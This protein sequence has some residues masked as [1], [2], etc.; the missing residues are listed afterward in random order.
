MTPPDR[1]CLLAGNRSQHSCIE[2]SVKRDAREGNA[3]PDNVYPGL[4]GKKPNKSFEANG[5]EPW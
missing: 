3:I 1:I 4:K 5:I 2:N